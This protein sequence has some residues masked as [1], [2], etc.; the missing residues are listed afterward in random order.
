ML[1][2]RPFFTIL[3]SPKEMQ[4]SLHG[5]KST[6]NAQKNECTLNYSYEY[7]DILYRYLFLSFASQ[8]VQVKNYIRIPPFPSNT[9]SV[10]VLLRFFWS[11]YN[12][13]VLTLVYLHHVH[14]CLNKCCSSKAATV[15]RCQLVATLDRHSGTGGVRKCT[16]T[17][18]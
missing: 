15:Q 17:S 3:G 11:R 9:R 18:N 14:G 7:T 4:N 2:K 1:S 6:K 8:S 10:L 12:I 5:V 16:Q 13:D